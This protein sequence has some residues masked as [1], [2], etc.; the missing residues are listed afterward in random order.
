M[1]LYSSVPREL[2]DF[3]LEPNLRLLFDMEL[4]GGLILI[5]NL[6]P[7]LP[8]DFDL[9]F[10]FELDDACVSFSRDDTA[11]TLNA[12]TEVKMSSFSRS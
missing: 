5:P 7:A 10:D 3:L 4:E 9:L 6:D 11:P 12:E 1:V 2:F 8:V